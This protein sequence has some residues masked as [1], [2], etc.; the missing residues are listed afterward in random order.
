MSVSLIR[1]PEI[2]FQPSII[3]NE[4]MGLGEI[5]QTLLSRISPEVR[6]IFF[7]AC[8]LISLSKD[9]FFSL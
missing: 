7:Q 9:F 8:H 4:Q 3:G 2:I 6:H 1:T 5:L